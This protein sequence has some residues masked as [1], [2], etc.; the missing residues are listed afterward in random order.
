MFT[1]YRHR[2]HLG[3]VTWTIYTN[4]CSNF[5]RRL[6]IKFGFDWPS[7]LGRDVLKIV[8]RRTDGR[9]QWQGY[10]ISPPCEPNGSGELIIGGRDTPKLIE[11]TK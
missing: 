3:H 1:I 9:M 6:Y 4:V 11:R 2:G 5:P 7:G 10:T 8:D